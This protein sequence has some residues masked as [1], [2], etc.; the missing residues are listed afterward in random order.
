MA[1]R[2]LIIIFLFSGYFISPAQN[3]SS[4]WQK[5]LEDF[6][7]KPSLG[8]Q[9]WGSYTMGEEVYDETQNDYHPVDDRLN[10][11]IRRTRIGL[12][13]RPYEN[14]SFKFTA[15]LDLVGRDILSGTEAGAN[16]GASPQ[17]RLWNAWLQWKMK[18]GS[19]KFNLVAGYLPPQIG[20]ESITSAFRSTSMEKSWSQNY[21]RRHL[22]GTGP[23]RAM[24][25][26]LGGLIYAKGAKAGWG[27]NIGVFNPAFNEYG[28]NSVGENYAPL[29]VGRL[30]A[31]L[32]EAESEKYSLG[33]KVNYLG[34]R[35]GLTL[36]VAGA[37]QGETDLFLANSVL[38]MDFL[39]NW[40]HFNLDGEWSCLYRQ[41]KSE[42]SAAEAFTTHAQ[43]GYLRLSYNIMLQH[44]YLL[45]PVAMIVSFNGETISDHQDQAQ[46]V[47]MPS[48]SEQILDLGVNFLYNENLKLSLH[49]THRNGDPGDF[50][51]GATVNNY[52]YQSGVGAIH[53]GDWM[54][55]GC[56]III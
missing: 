17:F 10:F 31:Y 8:L 18:K 33:Y 56:V 37:Y 45:E 41:G 35:R 39:F 32:G 27:Y 53:R 5:R 16:N 42:V 13:G 51:T 9:L 4:I 29:F 47:K 38:G 22:V 34:K 1:T 44:E 36:A 11:Q 21:L 50:G 20:R 19:E 15:G 3:N 46:M 52:F 14:L 24:G 49:Y 30:T 48:G 26:N 43:T 55:L 2:N 12:S 54:G 25:M 40:D 23:G 28:G 7:L 6:Q